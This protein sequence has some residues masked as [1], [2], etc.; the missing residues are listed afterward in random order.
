MDEG[1]DNGPKS[2]S[3]KDQIVARSLD[4]IFEPFEDS[5]DADERHGAIV[6]LLNLTA[7]YLNTHA[8]SLVKNKAIH[9]DSFG[10]SEAIM[11]FQRDVWGVFRIH[12]QIKKLKLPPDQKKSLLSKIE[13][14]GVRINS[15]DPLKTRIAAAFS[16]WMTTFRPISIIPERTPACYSQSQLV[17]CN[18]ALV[19]WI[20]CAFLRQY[21]KLDHGNDMDAMKRIERIR[22]DFTYRD[23]TLSSLEMLYC[24]IYRPN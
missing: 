15:K 16:L 21:G 8:K 5:D 4:A 9:C 22:Y 2:M 6:G 17:Q 23:L 13:E 18:G 3:D 10:A 24:S 7:I 14:A 12:N 11:R 20:S 19:H 1:V